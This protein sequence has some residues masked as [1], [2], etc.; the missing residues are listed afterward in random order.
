VDQEGF[1]VA[2][3]GQGGG[4]Q[5][6]QP[7]HQVQYPF[8]HDLLREGLSLGTAL[9]LDGGTGSVAVGAEDTA[10][11]GLRSEQCLTAVALME[12]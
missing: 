8:H 5:Q 11:P 12:I 2:G 9:A 7:D 1:A 6:N 4:C 10:V 3:A